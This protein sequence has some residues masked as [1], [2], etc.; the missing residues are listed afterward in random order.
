MTE[1]G[2][3]WAQALVVK[4]KFGA[5]STLTKDGHPFGSLVAYA[6]T[7][8]V[9]LLSEL[10]EH[11]QNLRADGRASLLVAE[12]G[13]SPLALGRVTLLGR[14]RPVARAE[15]EAGYL[16][17]HPDAAGYL[18]LRDFAFWR[19]D[20]ETVRWVGGFGRMGWIAGAD[21]G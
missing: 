6:G 14:C 9:L 3:D 4:G 20:V 12:S 7:Q 16:A 5:L 1:T 18:A 8:P 13:A 10:A 21:W 17:V 2:R 19:L 11:T 15:V